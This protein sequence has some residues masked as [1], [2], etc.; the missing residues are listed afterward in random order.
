MRSNP[1]RARVRPATWALAALLVLAAGTMRVAAAEIAP[2]FEV[3]PPRPSGHTSHR[4]AWITAAA[5]AALITGSFPLA[6]E[7]DR[8][9]AVYLAETDVSR[10]DERFQA[11][12]Q[13][14][15]VASG[16]LLA[17]E[18]LLATAIWLRFLHPPRVSRRL[19]LAVEPARCAVSLR[20]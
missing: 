4:L 18:G 15:R 19:S 20:F 6:N 5:G 9:Y 1:R 14:D 12:R 7:A 11:T 10:I 8:R 3:I 13:M 2:P 16:T 17:G